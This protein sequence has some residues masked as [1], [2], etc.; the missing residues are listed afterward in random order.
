[1]ALARALDLPYNL[2]FALDIATWIHF[3]RGEPQ[4]AQTCLDPLAPLAGEQGFQFFSA[5]SAILQGW[6]MTEQER[7]A[8]GLAQMRPGVVA[9]RATGAVMSR[10]TH[11]GLLAKTY[12]KVGQIPEGLATLAEAFAVMEKTGEYC[13]EA[14][15]YRLKGELTLQQANQKARGKNQ[16]A[17]V[18]TSPQPLTPNTRAAVAQEAEGYFLQA[19]DTARR[20]QAQSLELRAVMS[21]VRLRRRQVSHPEARTRLAEAHNMLSEVYHWFTEG[22]DTKDLQEAKALL[23]ESRQ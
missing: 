8:E 20:Q 5:E 7:E 17:K 13:L 16:K 19:V 12:G 3:Y 6:V 2:A 18:E 14:E 10:P 23:A 4:A 1:L 22:L 9:F 11:L 15:M 21:L